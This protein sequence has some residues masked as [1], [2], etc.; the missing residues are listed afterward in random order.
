[1]P[2]VVTAS[3]A[4]AAS[5]G[6]AGAAMTAAGAATDVPGSAV[7]SA[8]EAGSHGVRQHHHL[9]AR[10]NNMIIITQFIPFFYM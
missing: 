1:M 8:L 9:Q 3:A 6:V 7:E 4:S 5:G 2:S 10:L